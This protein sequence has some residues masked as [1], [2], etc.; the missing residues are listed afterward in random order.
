M[1][2]FRHLVDTHWHITENSFVL[3]TW[4]FL[5]EVCTQLPSCRAIQL[6]K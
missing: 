6:L 1:R 2:T 3:A 5:V 4:D